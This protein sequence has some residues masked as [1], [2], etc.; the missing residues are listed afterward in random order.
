[1][2]NVS[3]SIKKGF[4]YELALEEGKQRPYRI[5]KQLS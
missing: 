3:Y 5:K 2:K 1:M 4:R